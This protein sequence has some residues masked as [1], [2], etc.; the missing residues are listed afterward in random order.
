MMNNAA[1]TDRL[2][3]WV[4]GRHILSVVDGIFDHGL[5]GSPFK[6]RYE[7]FEPFAINDCFF[8]SQQQ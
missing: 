1:W 4:D 3:F 2:Q 8:V 6:E 5:C 7:S